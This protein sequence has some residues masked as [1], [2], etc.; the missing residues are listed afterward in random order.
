LTHEAPH[1]T[2]PLLHATPQA[3]ASHV[4]WPFEGEAHAWV[5]PP[6]WVGSVPVL[7]HDVPQTVAAQ[8]VAHCGEVPEVSQRAPAPVH[9]VVH[10]PQRSVVVR[11][12]SHP[13]VGSP[14]Q[15]P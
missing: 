6:Q 13:S 7:T 11:S 14:L 12:A 3:P 5:H 9:A 15:S 4:A 1:A 2:Y 10:D 8:L